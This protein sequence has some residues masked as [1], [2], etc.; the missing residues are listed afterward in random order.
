MNKKLVIGTVSIF[1]MTSFALAQ[2][3]NQNENKP[4]PKIPSV[5]SNMM[6]PPQIST[7]DSA[8]DAQVKA[9]LK[10]MEDKVLAIR[11]EYEAKIKAIVGNKLERPQAASG[12]PMMRGANR[13]EG[14][15]RGVMMNSS[16]APAAQN[17]QTSV[18]APSGQ[19]TLQNSE[20]TVNTIANTVVNTATITNFLKSFFNK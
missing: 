16:G 2:Q 8:K 10:E 13:G 12:T 18:V 1:M 4:Q 19:P 3:D 15:K 6:V 5:I 7:G 9:L 20:A 17:T 11:T 14:I